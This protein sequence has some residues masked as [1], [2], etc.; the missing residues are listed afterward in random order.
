MPTNFYLFFV[1][2]LIPLIVGF[3]YYHPKLAGTAWMR[4]NQ[5]TEDNLKGGNMALIMGMAY[6]LSVILSFFFSSVVIHQGAL[7]SLLYPDILEMGSE[8]QTTF[9]EFMTTYGDR[10][11]TFG[12]G[13][14]H[15][16]M[17]TL[18]F[19][20]PVIAIISI[21]ER[22]SWKYVLIHVGYWAI[23]LALVGGLLS[24]T[25]EYAAIG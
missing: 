8:A 2:G 23:T 12:H 13:V 17:A 5:F 9:N 1:A 19:A 22:R 18:F 25:L 6:L 20:F 21:F 10:H 24:A 15:G 14:A 16:I 11:R 7:F 3:V 4:V